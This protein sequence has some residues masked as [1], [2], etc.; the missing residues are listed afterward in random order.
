MAPATPPQRRVR[1]IADDKKASAG[2]GASS[3][4]NDAIVCC[5]SEGALY[6]SAGREGD[7]CSGY[8]RRA[9]SRQ[10]GKKA[11]AR[12]SASGGGTMSRRRVRCSLG[13]HRLHHRA[14]AASPSAKSAPLHCSALLATIAPSLSIFY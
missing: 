9:P 12:P 14:N 1:W 3:R 8:H 2:H 4:L 11:P 5:W 6:V 10:V 7:A 13:P